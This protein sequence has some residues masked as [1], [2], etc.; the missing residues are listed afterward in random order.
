MPSN[1]FRIIGKL[2]C[3][4]LLV[5]TFALQTLGQHTSVA[6]A[7]AIPNDLVDQTFGFGTGRVIYPMDDTVRA[8]SIVRSTAVQPDGKIVL[9]AE[10]T[11]FPIWRCA[12]IRLDAAGNLDPTFGT[13]GRVATDIPNRTCEP[14]DVIIQPDGK[15]VVAGTSQGGSLQDLLLLRYNHD[16]SLD[17]T[18]GGGNGMVLTDVGG[19]GVANLANA[20]ALQTDGK[21]IAAGRA[22]TDA[23]V[24][25][26]HIDGSLDTSFDTDGI[27]T[28]SFGPDTDDASGVGVTL[29]G[30]IVIAGNSGVL[31]FNGK[32]AAAR[33]LANGSLDT[34]FGD[35]GVAI[36]SF[37]SSSRV[38][39]M[40]LQPDGKI[41]AVG[42]TYTAT[43]MDMA[44]VRFNADGSLDTS[45]NGDGKVTTS[46][47][48]LNDG[49][50]DEAHS[51]LLQ[52]DG[53]IVLAGISRVNSF[54]SSVVVNAAVRYNPNG[55]LD[56]TFGRG[57]ISIGHPGNGLA[58]ALQGNRII[59]A[60]S[61]PIGT[62][63]RNMIS[64]MR[65][66][67]NGSVDTAFSSGIVRTAIG[68][69][70]E[71]ANAVA[72]QSDGNIVAAG[73]SFSAATNND[74]AL[75]RYHPRG[76]LDTSFDSD[77]MVTTA[78]G[79]G[80][81]TARD[82]V[83]QPD[84]KIIALGYSLVS[85]A[86]YDLALV[87]YNADG[88]L[89]TGFGGGD[90]IVI[91]PIGAGNDFGSA[92]LLQPDG[93]IIAFG[94]SVIGSSPDFFVARYH[95]DGTLD[96][97]FGGGNGFVITPLATID[98]ATSAVL[99][100]DGKII[101]AG[102]AGDGSTDDFLI[103]RYNANGSLD[104]TFDGDGILTTALNGFDFI[105][106]VILQPD[107]KIIAVGSS[108]APAGL[109]AVAVVRYNSDGTLDLGFGTDG[110]VIT[111]VN[112]SG[113]DSASGVDLMPDG[114]IVIA[115]LIE[116][117]FSQ[118]DFLILRYEADGTL[119]ASYGSS[120]IVQ[121]AASSQLGSSDDFARDVIVQPD[122]KIVAAGFAVVDGSRD[123]AIVRYGHS[124]VPA[125]ITFVVNSPLDTIDA[126]QGD[127]LCRDANGNCTLRAAIDE[128]NAMPGTVATINF[129]IPAAGVQTITLSST[130]LASETVIIDGYTQPGATPNSLDVGNNANLLIDINGNGGSSSLIQCLDLALFSV[131]RGLAVRNCDVNSSAVGIYIRGS[132]VVEGNF[133]GTDPTGTAA[134]GNSIGVS[135]TYCRV[136][137]STPASRNLVSGNS[138][139]GISASGSIQGNYAGT[140]RSGMLPLGNAIG[141]VARGTA[142]VEGNLVA[143]NTGVGVQTI[144]GSTIRGNSVFSNGGLGLDV[145]TA[146]V[147]PNDNCDANATQNFPMIGS[148]NSSGGTT[149]ITGILTGKA[150]T[151]YTLEFFSNTEGDPSGHGEGRTS[152][153]T[154]DVTT[155]GTCNALIDVDLPVALS[156]GE[157]VTATAMSATGSTSEFSNHFPVEGPP[158]PFAD[159]S[160]SIVDAPDPVIEGKNLTYTITISNAGPRTATAFTVTDTLDFNV[161]FVSASPGCSLLG[162]QV[163]CSITD[164]AS[165]S[166]TSVDIVVA[167]TVY[168][169]FY[170]V[171]NSVTLSYSQD[172]NPANNSATASTYVVTGV[173]NT[174]N[175]AFVTSTD[176]TLT[177]MSSG[178]TTLI[179]GDL[180][181]VTAMGN[182]GFSFCF[183]GAEAPNCR[184]TFSLNDNGL[185]R[186]DGGS[187]GAGEPYQPIGQFAAHL[188][189]FATNQRTHATGKVHYKTTGNAPDRVLTIEW[190]NMQSDPGIGGTPDL[191]YQV[192]LY[193]TTGVIEYIY[194]HMQLSSAA[195][196]DP[197]SNDPQI[198]FSVGSFFGQIGTVTAEQDGSPAPTYNGLTDTPVNNLY[199]AG[200]IGALSS[201][202]E[203][204]RRVFRFIPPVPG[205]PTGLTGSNVT[206]VSATLDWTDNSNNENGFM[207]LRSTD[208]VTFN[209]DRNLQKNVSSTNISN[210]EPGTNYMFRVHAVTEGGLSSPAEVTVSTLPPEEFVSVT[211]GNWFTAST[212]N[213]NRIPTAG[214]NVTIADGTTVTV[215]GFGEAVNLTVGQSASGVLQFSPTQS[216]AVIVKNAVIMPNASV[217][218]AVSGSQSHT[219]YVR[220]N[221]INN[222]ILSGDTATVYFYS[223]DQPHTFSGSSP[224]PLRNLFLASGQDV[225]L[226]TNA[227]I[228]GQLF[229]GTGILR[230]AET[231]TLTLRPTSTV[232][233]GGVQS[234]VIGE[235]AQEFA[236]AGARLFPVGTATGYSP[237]T[238]N[239]T[240]LNTVPSTLKV[241]AIDGAH[242]NAPN[243]AAALGRYW[244][245]S[246]TGD[247]TATLAF[248][249]LQTDVPA[250]S[251][252]TLELKRYSGSGSVFDTIPAT[253][254]TSLNRMTTTGGITDFSDWTLLS[255]L[256]PT[257]ATVSVSGRVMDQF[258]GVPRALLTITDMTGTARSTLSNQF[259]NYHFDG[260]MSGQTYVISVWHRSYEFPDPTQTVTVNDAIT[261]LNFIAADPRAKGGKGVI[262]G[263]VHD[264][265][266]VGIEGVSIEISGGDLVEP[267]AVITGKNGEYEIDDVKIGGTYIMTASCGD[268]VFQIPSQVVTLENDSARVDFIASRMP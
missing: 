197:N 99:Q 215:A 121:T 147:T 124:P 164:L 200:T 209:L 212:W 227:S 39:D 182:I 190:L 257:A 82:V 267:V 247:L 89:D 134:E 16:G 40:K 196:G 2:T 178:T 61:I 84:G 158:T 38:N 45:F 156:A 152:I 117:F 249:Y 244:A 175:Y 171:D 207:I 130:L 1:A 62:T 192:R 223:G 24:V 118:R 101:G 259:G 189:A 268:L 107:S 105:S 176:G 79:S 50:S 55:S 6:P 211:D 253:I 100:P 160:V 5:L 185:I 254:D 97:S 125:A 72:L 221:L 173:P 183:M 187:V 8:D 157:L 104:T 195:A 136:G 113:N 230:V 265:N 51:V 246:E 179:G 170:T 255:P 43:E 232:G 33:L 181:D 68:T 186:F 11:T 60:G 86:N 30:K 133:V 193:E 229:L 248:N 7:G 237:V 58:A 93:K 245:L 17:T 27:R 210:L 214:D 75:A 22:Q 106:T 137:G 199:T 131:V 126:A 78:I 154:A 14:R 218:S 141:I 148:A 149:N 47:S 92:V 41:V 109:N 83:I 76:V 202:G 258:G 15:I 28:L 19:S 91:T 90:G 231:R 120:G 194:G 64:T 102:R 48:T 242:P 88:S 225:L 10:W 205:T 228:T 151:T 236:A 53:K 21:I 70:N 220:G 35:N 119:D 26:Y 52:T 250:V 129:E 174:V 18:F 65:F 31:T 222:G 56:D 251:E 162:N 184:D 213:L 37:L 260:V 256:A 112:P 262:A 135:C 167:T 238:A 66:R 49:P 94:D 63:N 155:T 143:F 116:D 111:D 264:E 80:D 208:G 36:T 123:F 57:G 177:D 226:E 103:V 150:N 12:L 161:S 140:D 23:A 235:L 4:M 204:T 115:G 128:S 145:G 168:D 138:V 233:G 69:S 132:G 73:F 142:A 201:G 239:I 127:G 241:K 263:R 81:D 46:L 165:G 243:P 188:T 153:G 172:F 34:S 198:G 146:G 216:G 217:A 71:E 206:K 32:F 87:R 266:G 59:L 54:P 44:A 252:G 224:M 122:G 13:N 25:R 144:D 169:V 67:S 108:A 20:V 261:D 96:T 180:N 234:Y 42:V 95:H 240:Q 110:K 191:T 29:D 9:V 139:T 77:G 203:G 166:S 74:F 219:V 3:W 159:L 85:A 98:R 114:D 163:T